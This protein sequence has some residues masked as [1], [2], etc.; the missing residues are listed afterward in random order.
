MSIATFCPFCG[1]FGVILIEFISN[2]VL[3]SGEPIVLTK[4][5]SQLLYILT[6]I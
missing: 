6:A 1:G 4:K 2:L 5:S 3:S